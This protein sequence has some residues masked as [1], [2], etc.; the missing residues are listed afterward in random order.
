MRREGKQPTAHV[1]AVDWL[2]KLR[3]SDERG[4]RI[5]VRGAL[6]YA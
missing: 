5:L 2:M 1:A 6:R 3:E 4:K